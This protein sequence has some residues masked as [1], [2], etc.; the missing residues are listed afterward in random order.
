MPNASPVMIERVARAIA[1]NAGREDW[2]SFTSVA[3]AAV[4]ALREPTPEM[5]EAAIPNCPDWG[6]LPQDWQAM[7]DYVLNEQIS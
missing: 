1:A 4:V 7:I 2:A 3:R 5:L 6:D